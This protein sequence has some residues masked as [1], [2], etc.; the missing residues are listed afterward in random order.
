MNEST[1]AESKS[2]PGRIKRREWS[3]EERQLIVRASLKK[4]TTVNAVARLYGVEPWQIYDWRKK[5]SQAAQQSKAATLIPVEVTE[6]DQVGAVNPKQSFSVLIEA[7][8]MRVTMNGLVDAVVL[9]TVLDC[10]AR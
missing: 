6:R 1:P 9:R 7:P 10:L 5:A 4:G 3:D 2:Q 8:S